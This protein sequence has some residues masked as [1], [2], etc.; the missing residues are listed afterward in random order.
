MQRKDLLAVLPTGG[1]KSTIYLIPAVM[2]SQSI[3]VLVA[4][5]ALEQQIQQT[6]ERHQLSCTAWTAT[7]DP[8]VASSLPSVITVMIESAGTK[9][10][11]QQLSQW[12]A[13]EVI[14]H[15]VL[16]EV[17]L[18]QQWATFRPAML[19]VASLRAMRPIVPQCQG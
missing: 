18:I 9:A 11:R 5:V 2:R 10:F 14:H 19:E 6:C 1:G 17:H 12:T 3:I 16:D 13:A 7:A 8:L 4:T 15:I